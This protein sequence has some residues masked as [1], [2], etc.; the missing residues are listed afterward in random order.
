MGAKLIRET[1]PLAGTL[2]VEMVAVMAK[3][4]PFAEKAGMKKV[5]E[6]QPSEEALRVA[7]ALSSFGF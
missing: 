2:Y 3:Y 1:L 5:C 4:N 6:Q 7:D